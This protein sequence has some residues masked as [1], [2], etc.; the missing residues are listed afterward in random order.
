MPLSAVDFANEVATIKVPTRNGELLVRYYPN[1]MTPKRAQLIRAAGD[2]DEDGGDYI[3][4]F[5]EMVEYLDLN[6]P[7]YDPDELDSDGNPRQMIGEGD[8]IPVEPEF[9]ALLP[10]ALL[11]RIMDAMQSDMNT[12]TPKAFRSRKSS[13]ASRNGSRG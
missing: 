7:L 3:E 6:G 4:M 11:K 8:P 1:A 13:M 2:D 10:L 5:C 9:V 12:E